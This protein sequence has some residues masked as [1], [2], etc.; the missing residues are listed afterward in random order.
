MM[1]TWTLA[2]VWIG[3]ALV[4][5]LISIWFRVATALSENS[6]ARGFGLV[7]DNS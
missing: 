5:T 6:A 7:A 2:A 3:L 4:A 1:E